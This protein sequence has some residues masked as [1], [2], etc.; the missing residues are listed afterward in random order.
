MIH[1]FKISIRPQTT[2]ELLT[3]HLCILEYAVTFDWESWL[4]VTAYY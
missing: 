1:D 4:G 2:G 3:Q